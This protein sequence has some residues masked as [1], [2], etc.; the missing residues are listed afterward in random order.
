LSQ[1]TEV[2]VEPTHVDK[3][4]NGVLLCVQIL[5]EKGSDLWTAQSV[6]RLEVRRLR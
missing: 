2:H 6:V 1:S 3:V 5:C 4:S